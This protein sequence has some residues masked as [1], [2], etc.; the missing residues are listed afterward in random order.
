[1]PFLGETI[2]KLRN[3]LGM[4]QCVFAVA[5]AESA[6][7]IDAKKTSYTPGTV[8]NWERGSCAPGVNFLDTYI[9]LARK[10]D[11]LDL[12]IYVWP[13]REDPRIIFPEGADPRR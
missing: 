2:T 1:M 10:E 13:S 7:E 12:P 6:R 9:N 8:Y 5:L 11:N 3:R 4:S